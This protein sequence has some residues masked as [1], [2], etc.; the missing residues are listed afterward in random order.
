MFSLYMND[1]AGAI[2]TLNLGA[3]ID[4]LQL[5]ILLYVDDVA[6]IAPDADSLQLMLDKLSEW[7][8]KWRL[9]VIYLF[10]HNLRSSFEY[11]RD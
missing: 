2:K 6:L 3:D 11:Y 9:T 5:S 7:C 1:L 8:S 4:E 10:L